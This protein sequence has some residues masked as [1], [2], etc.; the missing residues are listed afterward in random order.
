VTGR[1]AAGPSRLALTSLRL[2][3]G[4]FSLEGDYRSSSGRQHGEFRA[5]KGPLSIR[6]TIPAGP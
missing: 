4:N 1:L 2:S 5:K 6:F 3:A